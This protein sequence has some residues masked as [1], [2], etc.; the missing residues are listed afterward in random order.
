MAR[1]WFYF[2]FCIKD[3]YVVCSEDVLGTYYDDFYF[4]LRKDPLSPGTH[5]TVTTAAIL[6][7]QSHEC[8]EMQACTT[9]MRD[10]Q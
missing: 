4:I 9:T 2:K 8:R 5:L 7:P 3:E 1:V 6:L 10:L